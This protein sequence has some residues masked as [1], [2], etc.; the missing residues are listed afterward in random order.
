MLYEGRGNGLIEDV[1][2]AIGYTA[3]CTLVE[4]WGGKRPWIPVTLDEQHEF[5]LILGMPAFRAL[6]KAFGG[7][8][9]D[10]PTDHFREVIKR[11]RIVANLIPRGLGSKEIARCIGLKERQVLN[12]RQRLEAAGVLPIGPNSGD[13]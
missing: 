9:L 13:R 7:T 4:W 8:Q 5:A 10:V 6:V 3:T 2:A 12:I 1:C 11:D